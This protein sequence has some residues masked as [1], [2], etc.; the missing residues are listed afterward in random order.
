MFYRKQNW[1]RIEISLGRIGHKTIK[2]SNLISVSDRSQDVERFTLQSTEMQVFTRKVTTL[3]ISHWSSVCFVSA[4]CTLMTLT[5]Q[6]IIK[7]FVWC[8]IRELLL[9]NITQTVK[10]LFSAFCPVVNWLIKIILKSFFLNYCFFNK[11]V[12]KKS[13]KRLDQIERPLVL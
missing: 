10:S 6:C 8:R 2:W 13:S 3:I 5:F 1:G 12:D 7:K 4:V 9:I 11:I